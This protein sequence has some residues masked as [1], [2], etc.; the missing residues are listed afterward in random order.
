MAIDAFLY[1][2]TDAKGESFL[3]GGCTDLVF[4]KSIQLKTFAMNA[5]SS[6]GTADEL[7]A[8]GAKPVE[9]S[10]PTV[11]DAKEPLDSFSITITKDYDRASTDLFNNYA[12]AAFRKVIPFPMATVYCRIA[13]PLA[14]Y[15]EGRK[16]E[17]DDVSFLVYEFCDLY[18]C[19][20]SMQSDEKSS[21]P[22][23]TCKFYFDKYRITYRPQLATGSLGTRVPLG[24]N[25]KDDKSF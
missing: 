15:G 10:A 4:A 23:E 6:A 16:P 9:G 1:L 21:I 17:R 19:E 12:I 22:G 8:R 24:W 3:K 7:A 25:F 18:I 2:F 11:P 20:Y 14:A 5:E 13:G